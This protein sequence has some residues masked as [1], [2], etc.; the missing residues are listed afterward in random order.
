MRIPETMGF[1]QADLGFT[2][3]ASLQEKRRLENISQSAFHWDDKYLPFVIAGAG[4]VIVPL[5]FKVMKRK[6][7]K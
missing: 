7:K 3:L 6:R 5:L 2:D 4:I 1:S